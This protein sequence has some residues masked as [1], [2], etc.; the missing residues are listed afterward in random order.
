MKNEINLQWQ[1]D[2]PIE[3]IWESFTEFDKIKQ[4]EGHQVKP[5]V[6]YK[7]KNKNLA[8]AGMGKCI[9]KF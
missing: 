6:G 5:E 1:F 9:L 7:W 8:P 2:K 4:W 3:I